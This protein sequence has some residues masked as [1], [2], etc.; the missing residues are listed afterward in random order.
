M[1][2][3]PLI[4]RYSITWF[5]S[6]HQAFPNFCQRRQSPSP[7]PHGPLYRRPR[8]QLGPTWSTFALIVLRFFTPFGPSPFSSRGGGGG[9]NGFLDSFAVFDAAFSFFVGLLANLADLPIMLTDCRVDST[10]RLQIGES[11]WWL[12]GH[13]VVPRSNFGAFTHPLSPSHNH[14]SL[15]LV[16]TL[17]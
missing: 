15:S 7:K 14:S 9:G 5:N 11:C 16:L 1:L 13:V 2:V 12:G 17:S 6:V 10:D 3:S 4:S 8:Q